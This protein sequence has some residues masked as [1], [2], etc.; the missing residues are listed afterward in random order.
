MSYSVNFSEDSKNSSKI[1]LGNVVMN[2]SIYTPSADTQVFTK[3]L[4]GN[5]TKT[6]TFNLNGITYTSPVPV[7]GVVAGAGGATAVATVASGGALLAPPGGVLPGG[8]LP[9]GALPAPPGGALPPA[10]T[11]EQITAVNAINNAETAISDAINSAETY[12]NNMTSSTLIGGSPN[13][14]IAAINAVEAAKKAVSAA[15]D[16]ISP[17]IYNATST[18]VSDNIKL[19]YKEKQPKIAK[20]YNALDILIEALTRYTFKDKDKLQFDINNVK[21]THDDLLKTTITGGAP[22]RFGSS[23]SKTKRN[24][25]TNRRF[26]KKSYKR[27][28]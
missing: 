18:P 21:T 19:K 23:S 1:L 4:S 13:P 22:L 28:H 16:A 8:A 11:N 17:I 12:T 25:R 20:I 9:G 7:A 10:P 26:A 2:G 14:N 27:R 6:S 15:S 5:L 24:R 3:D